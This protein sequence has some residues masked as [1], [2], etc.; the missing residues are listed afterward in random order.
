[1]T[2]TCL[3]PHLFCRKKNYFTNPLFFN[4]CR[5][6]KMQKAPADCSTEADYNPTQ[7][8]KDRSYEQTMSLSAY[9]SCATAYA[10]RLAESFV[11]IPR[12]LFPVAWKARMVCSLCLVP[13]DCLVGS[14]ELISWS[15]FESSIILFE[16]L[17][18]TVQKQSHDSIPL[19]VSHLA[20]FD[21]I[22]A[23]EKQ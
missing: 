5:A 4:G 9:T 22:V 6:K 18:C 1:M 19:S 7:Q 16:A 15:L 20:D 2:C 13:C 14:Y 3:C 11:G 12:G 21:P 23:D 8:I 17:S 10:S